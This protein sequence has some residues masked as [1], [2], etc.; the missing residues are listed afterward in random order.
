[1]EVVADFIPYHIY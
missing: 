1:M